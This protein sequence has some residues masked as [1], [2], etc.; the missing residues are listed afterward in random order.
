MNVCCVCRSVLNMWLCLQECIECAA[1]FC[2]TSECV[3]MF[4]GLY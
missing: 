1:K 2:R 4:A 3:A